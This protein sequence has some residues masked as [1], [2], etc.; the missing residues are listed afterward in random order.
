MLAQLA[1]NGRPVKP[2]KSDPVNP[3]QVRKQLG[4][5]QSEFW[6]RVNVTQSGGCRY[7]SGRRIPKP[8]QSLLRICY[9]TPAQAE[10]ELKKLRGQ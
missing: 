4:L 2:K 8:V 1:M 10:D 9:G 6:S 3:L 7:E 5:S